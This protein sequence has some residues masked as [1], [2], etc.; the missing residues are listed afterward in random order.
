MLRR[1]AN[2]VPLRL[3]AALDQDFACARF[4]QA[5]DE[6]ERRGFAGA[7]AAE[8]DECF[9]ARDGEVQAVQQERGRLPSDRRRCANRSRDLAIKPH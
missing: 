9:A 6:L 7:A 1:K 8:K 5:V 2:R 4:Q 3:R